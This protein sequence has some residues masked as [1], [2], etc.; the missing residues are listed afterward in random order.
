MNKIMLNRLYVLSLNFNGLFF[1]M[2]LNK[3]KITNWPRILKIKT[4]VSESPNKE[5]GR[6]EMPM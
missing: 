1:N 5:K 2:S 3:K 4:S 6:H